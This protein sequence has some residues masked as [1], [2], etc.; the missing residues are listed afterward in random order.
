M[1]NAAG[2]VG[3]TALEAATDPLQ[4]HDPVYVAGHG[5]QPVAALLPRLE[6]A[7][8]LL[9]EARSSLLPL[10]PPRGSLNH[11]PSLPAAVPDTP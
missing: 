11:L 5:F 10:T 6:L 7:K 9:S 3:Q 2:A 8:R 4:Q 1:S